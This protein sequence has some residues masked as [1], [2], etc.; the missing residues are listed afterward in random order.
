[1][2]RQL[3][4]PRTSTVFDVCGAPRRRSAQILSILAALA[5]AVCFGADWDS[6]LSKDPPGNFPPLRPARATF[7]FGWSGVK[8]AT[9]EVR[10]TKPGGERYQMEA[11]GETIGLARTLWRYEIDYRSTINAG[12]LK[13][14]DLMQIEKVRGKKIVTA[15]SFKPDEVVSQETKEPAKTRTRRFLFAGVN[16]LLST[17]LYLR[18]QPLKNGDV[19]RMVVYPATSAYLATITVTGRENITVGSGRYTAIK[20]DLQLSKI[21]KKRQLEPHKK[22]RRAS[23]WLSDDSDRLPVRAEAQIFVG[24]VFADLQSVQF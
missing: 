11:T 9:A 14:I 21:N 20:C 13:P 3:N 18:S 1:M 5:P 24:T 4:N 2:Y 19:Y 17:A 10:L 7:S 8:A 16:D 23:I 6:T 12:T 15:V 22:F